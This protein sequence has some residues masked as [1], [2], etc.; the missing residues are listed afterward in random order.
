MFES[1]D[2]GHELDV[3]IMSERGKSTMTSPDQLSSCW[4]HSQR[5]ERLEEE[6][7]WS[8][9]MWMEKLSP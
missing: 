8:K 3:G 5:W 1:R 9:Q 6:K 2:C 4:H 7:V